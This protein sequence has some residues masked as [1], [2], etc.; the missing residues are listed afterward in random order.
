MLGVDGAGSDAISLK[1][2][3]IDLAFLAV[4]VDDWLRML[5]GVDGLMSERDRELAAGRGSEENA[6]DAL[7]VSTFNSAIAAFGAA[8][9]KPRCPRLMCRINLGCLAVNDDVEGALLGL[10]LGGSGDF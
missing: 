8:M 4:S 2:D 7:T 5:C 9:P 3:F 6:G 10:V 1:S